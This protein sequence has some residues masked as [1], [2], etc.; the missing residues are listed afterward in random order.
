MYMCFQNFQTGKV[1]VRILF[2]QGVILGTVLLQC[3]TILR[4]KEK[5]GR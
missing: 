3:K 2:F 5:K 4:H 1:N